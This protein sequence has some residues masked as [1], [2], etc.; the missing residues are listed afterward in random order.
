MTKCSSC[1]K[2]FKD[3]QSLGSHM[4]NLYDSDDDSSLPN[5]L[6]HETSQNLAEITTFLNKQNESK[7]QK[8]SKKTEVCHKRIHFEYDID[9]NQDMEIFIVNEPDKRQ[10][11]DEP[12]FNYKGTQSYNE[13]TEQNIELFSYASDSQ[14][15]NTSDDEDTMSDLFDA[16]N[17]DDNKYVEDIHLFL[18]NQKILKILTCKCVHKFFNKYS[19]CNNH[20]LLSTLQAGRVFIENLKLSSF[21]W[22]K[23][24]NVEQ[25]I[26][27]GAHVMPIILYSNA[28]LCD[29]LG[30]MLRHPVFKTLGNIPL[31]HRNKTYAKSLLAIFLGLT[32]AL[33]ATYG[34]PNSFHPCHFRL[35]DHG[36]MNNIHLENEGII[37]RTKSKTK[38]LLH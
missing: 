6:I 30:K 26:P 24:K 5:Q 19:N 23:E 2:I 21:G 22:R 25:N 1:N 27:V 18:E 28:T 34:S 7:R 15:S 32:C 8:I 37:I 10:N 14:S 13:S 16:T 20:P 29:H 36:E 35:V 33:Y 31:A 12:L 11:L 3:C 4:K 17:I 38:H 9:N